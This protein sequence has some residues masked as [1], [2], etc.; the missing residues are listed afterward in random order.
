MGAEHDNRHDSAQNIFV[1]VTIASAL[2][3]IAVPLAG[4]LNSEQSEAARSISLV[5]IIRLS[6]LIQID[7]WLLPEFDKAVRVSLVLLA[8]DNDDV[9]SAK[10][11][12]WFS[13]FTV[14]PVK[15]WR[16]LV[17]KARP[18]RRAYAGLRALLRFPSA[19]LISPY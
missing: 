2:P 16:V 10:V 17:D 13:V 4:I 19:S 8:I 6:I 9:L 18:F 5:K 3:A 11:R 15:P 12:G 14:R 1:S 7:R